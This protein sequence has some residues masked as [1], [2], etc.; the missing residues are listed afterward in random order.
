MKDLKTLLIELD[1]CNR[2][3]DRIQTDSEYISGKVK[4]IWK[5]KPKRDYTRQINAII[6]AF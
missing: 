1:E 3:I 2:K 6:D 4:E 5:D